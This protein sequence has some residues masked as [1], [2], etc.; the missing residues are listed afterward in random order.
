MSVTRD[1]DA[2]VAEKV[3][4]KPTFQVAGQV[5][6]LRAKLPYARWE[7]LLATMRG[8]D[9]APHEATREFFNTVL[10]KADRERFLDLLTKEDS[11]DE[12]ESDLVGMDQMDSITDWVM[13]HFTGK[14]QNS[15]NGSSPGASGT[16]P[17]RNVVSLSARTTAS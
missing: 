16:G 11:D 13:E 12:D 1:F 6:T 4:A 8:D 9:I 7:K 14:L 5:F 17:Q 3:G 10:I 15:S 2:M